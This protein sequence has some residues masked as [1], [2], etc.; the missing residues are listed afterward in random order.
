MNTTFCCII[1]A[2]KLESLANA[3][4]YGAFAKAVLAEAKSWGGNIESALLE[5]ADGN[6]R[7]GGGQKLADFCEHLLAVCQRPFNAEE[8]AAA[9]EREAKL[10]EKQAAA[11]AAYE[12]AQAEKAAAAAAREAKLARLAE[13]ERLLAS[14]AAQETGTAS[15]TLR[16]IRQNGVLVATRRYEQVSYESSSKDAWIRGTR[17]ENA[18]FHWVLDAIELPEV[19][20]LTPHPLMIER[21]DGALASIPASGAVARLAVTREQLA[22]VATSAGAFA[23]TRPTL[24][25]VTGLPEPEAGRIYVV[26]AMVAEAVK[27]PDVFS[28]GEL[29]R[30]SAG[31]VVGARGLCYFI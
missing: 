30:D 23:V 29:I 4:T 11:V 3:P 13:I 20:N 24:G 22:P 21:V 5:G 7:C 26:S 18:Q 2:S 16:E 17:H 27:R 1:A 28:P 10:A 19:V 14:G 12:A 15:T 31:N 9:S 8:I 25:A 6:I